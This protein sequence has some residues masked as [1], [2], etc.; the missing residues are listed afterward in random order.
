MRWNATFRYRKA[1]TSQRDSNGFLT[2]PVAAP[3]VDGGLC[4]VER[5]A[6]AQH[7]IATDGQEF[8]YTYQ[9]FV[10]VS[11]ATKIAIGDTLQISMQSGEVFS[12]AVLGTDTTNKKHLAIWV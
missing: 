3:F 2:Q 4:Q 9:I 10:P 5:N 7:R 6:P 11:F 8:V 12:S 1:T